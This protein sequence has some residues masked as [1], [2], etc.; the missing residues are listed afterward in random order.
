MAA[1]R[2]AP[3]RR[4]ASMAWRMTGTYLANCSCQLICPCPTDNPPTGPDGQC[5]GV[6][7]FHIR[8]GN[9]DD[10][11]LAGTTFAFVNLFPSNLTAAS[12]EV[13]VSIARVACG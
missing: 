2:R 9:L 8:D 10:T 11:D 13:G 5:R 12:S 1:R 6:A 4:E 3:L 7:I